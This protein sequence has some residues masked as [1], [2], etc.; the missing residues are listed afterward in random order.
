MVATTAPPAPGST[1]TPPPRPPRER[2]RPSELTPEDRWTAAGCAVSALS[3]TWLVFARL[4]DGV[5]WFGFV[6]VAYVAFLILFAL[7]TTD[8][9]GR[10]AGIDR[11]ATVAVSTATIVLFVPLLWLVGY[12]VKRGLPALRP[13]FFT[14]DLAGI[15]GDALATDGGGKHAIIGTLEQVGLALVFTV[16]LAVSCAVFLNESR[17]R[18]R[19]PVRIVVDAMSGLPSVVAGLFVFAVFII[20]FADRA[21]VFGWHVFGYNGFM[22]SLALSMIMI[23]TVTRTVDVVLR[24]VPDGLREAGLALGA[25]RARVVWS[26]VLPTARS[27]VTTAVVLGIARAVGETAPLLFT[28][29]GYDLVNRNPFD[30]PQDSLPLFV[31]KNVQKPSHA[32]IDRGFTGALVLMIVV[33]TLFVIARVVGR[34]RSRARHRGLRARVATLVP[35]RREARP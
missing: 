10:L 29:F 12:V 11:V 15:G 34:D 9:L 20:P 2:R 22:A 1:R 18:F 30:G 19:R 23:P 21:P 33:L 6:V 25:S 5:G 7:V 31:W 8:R 4:T 3:L 17:S 27:G 16:P 14:E 32:S 24:L 13:S 26:V 35:S 28:S